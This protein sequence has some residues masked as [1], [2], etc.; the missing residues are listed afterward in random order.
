MKIKIDTQNKREPMGDLFGIFFEDINHAADGGL[1][2]EMVRNRSFEYGPIDN[3]EYR[4]LTAWEKIEVGGKINWSIQSVEPLSYKNPHYLVLE[5]SEA[6]DRIGVCNTGFNGGIP[7]KEGE[8]YNFSCFAKGMGLDEKNIHVALIDAAG[9]EL[10]GEDFFVGDSWAKYEKRL[11]SPVTTNTARLA[12]FVRGVGKVAFDCV[13][14]FPEETY[15]NRRNGMRKDIAEKLAE[16]KPK[17]MRFPGGCLIHDGS[18][19]LNER[20][21]MYRWKN[22]VG[23][24]IER[25]ARR[26]NWSYNQTLGLGFYEL[27]QFCEDIGTKP[28]PVIAAG[29]NPHGGQATPINE[30]QQWVDEALDLIEFA[31][32]GVDTKWGAVRAEMGH[33]E[34][35]NMEYL[36]IGNEEVGEAF[37]ERYSIIHKA[38]K[39]RHPEIKL[40]NSAGP[41]CAGY[42]YELGWKSARENGSELID[43]HYYQA[44]EWYIANHHRY[45]GYDGETKV[46]LGEYGSCANMWRNCL[47]EASFMIGLERNVKGVAL[48]C[49]A[50]LLCNV[51][52]RNWFPDLIYYDNHRV[53]GSGNYYVQKL[54]MNHQ[55]SYRL[56]CVEEDVGE[57]ILI[58]KPDRFMG[59]VC[60]S[61][62]RSKTRFANIMVKNL[63]T[64]EIMKVDDVIAHNSKFDVADVRWQNYSVSFTSSRIGDGWGF[65]IFFGHEDDKNHYCVEVGG[66]QNADIFVC[67]RE[68]GLSTYYTQTPFRVGGDKEYEVELKIMGNHL[69]LTINGDLMIEYDFTPAFM[70]P[71]YYAASRDD[72]GDVIVKLVNL[73]EDEQPVTIELEGLSDAEGILY[74]M[75]GHLL[76]DEN[77]FSRPTLIS[78]REFS[79]SVKSGVFDVVLPAGSIRVYR[80]K[81]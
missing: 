75:E 31:N 2:A 61:A 48:A 40:I 10:C 56:D 76:E 20:D 59:K 62:N 71:V 11:C 35:F 17:F 3:R 4:A 21:S 42:A 64:Q 36:G 33:P 39:E 6:G 81:E 34:S 29:Y 1:Y 80:F 77:S 69:S 5:V 8:Y 46:F 27:F 15:K 16:L 13:S 14:L 55:G 50:P 41:W 53:Y 74:A 63:D 18:L 73:T 9:N 44:P 24:V 49:Y 43:E 45:D 51:D 47:A 60:V 58:D 7:L 26:N 22:T 19:D 67:G 12:L 52:Y 68:K 38:V 65:N 23:E 78:P 25:P 66:W 30:M 37:F 32:G 79:V 54:F 72:N 57:L 28:I 70:K